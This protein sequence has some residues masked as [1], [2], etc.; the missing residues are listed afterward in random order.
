MTLTPDHFAYIADHTRAND[1]FMTELREA[2]KAA[3][4]PSISIGA[5]Q[6]SFMQ[7]ILKLRGARDV[8]EV[9]TLGGYSAIAMARALPAGGMVRTIELDPMHAD[10]AEA[11]I[12]K[13]DVADKVRVHRGAGADVLK[14]FA[15]GSADACFLDADKGNYPIY[16]EECLRILRPGGIVMAD[17]AL[18]F[19][20]LL[21]APEDDPGVG[22]IRRFNDIMAADNRLHSVIVPLGDGCWVGVKE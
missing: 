10:F 9:G 1:P 14:T 2:A 16:L 3:D 5:P 12:A 22:A 6:A 7:I 19:G 8:V 18:G 11:W 17:N 20:R 4:I 13:S 15:D 21:T